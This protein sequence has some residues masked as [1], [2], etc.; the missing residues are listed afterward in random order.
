MTRKHGQVSAINLLPM[1]EQPELR[2]AAGE[3]LRHDSALKHATG[4][5]LYV[6]DILEPTGTLYLAPG[7]ADVACGSVLA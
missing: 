4:E 3:A 5:A 1:G 2:G 7:M 6:D